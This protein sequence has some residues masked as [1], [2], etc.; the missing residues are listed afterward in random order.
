MGPLLRLFALLVCVPGCFFLAPIEETPPVEDEPPF[1]DPANDVEPVLGH[2]VVLQLDRPSENQLFRLLRV[3]DANPEQTLYWRAVIH[4]PAGVIATEPVEIPPVFR[5]DSPINYTY[6]PCAG[7]NK[8]LIN[9]ETSNDYVVTVYLVV[10][11]SEFIDQSDF[12]NI[13]GADV[14]PTFSDAF[15]NVSA[16]LGLF[17]NR[18]G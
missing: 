7:I 4:Y 17:D 14:P 13:P 16:R 1:F 2:H 11:D 3:F 5:D 12:F 10:S 6:V 18:L 15:A 9:N 8:V